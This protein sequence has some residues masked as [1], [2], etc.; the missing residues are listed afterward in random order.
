MKIETEFVDTTKQIGDLVD[1]L[2]LRHATPSLYPPT[3]YIDLEGKNLCREGSISIFT[4][5]MD[6]STSTKR[7]CLID[8][9]TLGA[10]AFNTSGAKG[11]TLKDILQDENIPKVFFDV[12]NDS[13][14]LFMHFGIALLGVEDVQLM[15]SATRKTTASRRLLNGLAKTVEDYIFAVPRGKEWANW[16]STKENGQRLFK[17]EYGGS[18]DIFNCR[19]IPEAIASYCVGDVQYLPELREKFWAHKPR[20]WRAMVGEEFQKRVKASQRSD[21]QPHGRDRALAPWSKEQNCT[22]DGWNYVPSYRHIDEVED[23]WHDDYNDGQ[24]DDWYDDGPTSCRD[25]ISDC[26]M[27]LYYSD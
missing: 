22:L 14:A 18:Y 21:Y 3:M 4:L 15:E 20:D 26:D 23:D 8:V 9:H 17:A 12:R 10:H 24:D 7:A 6:T 11:K 13:D 2:V 5:L 19:P 1:W 16:K 27:H 25:I